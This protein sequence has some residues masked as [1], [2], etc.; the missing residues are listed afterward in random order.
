MAR[1]VDSMLSKGQRRGEYK[2]MAKE[3]YLTLTKRLFLANDASVTRA[4]SS[5]LTKVVDNILASNGNE[6]KFLRLK[7]SSTTVSKK[8]I[9]VSGGQE[10]LHALGF[11]KIRDRTTSTFVLEKKDINMEHLKICKEWINNYAD[12]QE[13]LNDNA[14]IVVVQVRQLNGTTLVAPF[15]SNEKLQD[16]Y[17]FVLNFRTDGGRGKFVL[18][19]SYPIVEYSSPEHLSLAIGS[20]CPG[21][22]TTNFKLS[23]II[24]KSNVSDDE[25]FLKG[26]S[27]E[28]MFDEQR[29]RQQALHDQR[30]SRIAEEKQKKIERQKAINA[31]REDREDILDKTKRKLATEAN[32]LKAGQNAVEK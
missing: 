28:N 7:T 2:N 31:F 12:E 20:L 4:C 3:K 9:A 29:R 10:F 30:T 15:T 13:K 23:L 1:L 25:A 22:N 16:I 14:T 18:L 27:N 32:R 26:D 24:K 19:T 17:D 6:P 8:I 5:V 21:R 11:A